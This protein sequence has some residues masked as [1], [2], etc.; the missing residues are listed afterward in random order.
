MS[1]AQW[2]FGGMIPENLQVEIVLTDCPL[3]WR[4]GKTE[5]KE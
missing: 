4:L 2:S 3:L 5:M 1:S